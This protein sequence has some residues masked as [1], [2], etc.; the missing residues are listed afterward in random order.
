MATKKKELKFQEALEK[1]SNIVEKM[2]DKDLSLEDSLKLFQ[3]GMELAALCNK[4][5]DE[6]ERKINIVLK[7][8][9]GELIE[10]GFIPEE[11]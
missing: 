8:K 10:E 9:D 4:Q 3:D 7:G 11:E 2:E 5:L 1:L 6:A